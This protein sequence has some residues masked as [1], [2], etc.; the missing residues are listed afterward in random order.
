[1]R[2][3]DKPTLEEWKE[4]YE[5][6]IKFKEAAPWEWMYDTD[7]FGVLNPETE[8]IGYCT[9][10]G[11]NKEFYGMAIYQGP[12]GFAILDKIARGDFRQEDA[13]Y[14]QKCLMLSFDKRNYIE[15]E[16]MEII[17]QIGVRFDNRN[18][19]PQF[20]DYSPGYYPWHIDRK[21]AA[22]FMIIIEQA[23]EI[24]SKV[25]DNKDK[26]MAGVPYRIL[27]RIPKK[28]GTKIVWTDEYI[29][30]KIMEKK[31]TIPALSEKHEII[32]R[33][34]K[35]EIDIDPEMTWEADDFFS[36]DPVKD[37]DEDIRPFFP[38]LLFFVEQRSGAVMS[39]GLS[40]SAIDIIT[41][42]FRQSFLDGI[43][44]HGAFPKKLNI[45]NEKLAE[46]LRPIAK[47]LDITIVIT[48]KM[49][50]FDE[51]KNFY[52]QDFEFRKTMKKILNR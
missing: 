42:K 31:I 10:M 27:A 45:R 32:S 52:N 2:S 39:I 35:K 15:K 48:D 46:I 20:R 25:K 13:K 18:F 49:A 28:N 26:Y 23:L 50:M 24:F 8:D 30:P 11:N 36:P 17:K 22:Y 34:I 6:A 4:L 43:L 16:E 21:Q 44:K 33:K 29:V 41:T 5:L 51:A 38:R 7:V 1:M 40:E 12:E 19:W 14:M 3:K 47:I 9:V 37:D